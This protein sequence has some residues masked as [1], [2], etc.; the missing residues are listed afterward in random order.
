[1]AIEQIVAALNKML[2]ELKSTAA[3]LR[4]IGVSCGGPLDPHTG[5]I[6]APPNLATWIDVPI[7]KILATE[8]GCPVVL[9]NDANA[10][11]MAEHRYGAGK[12]THHMVFL[13]M[14]TGLGAG[15]IIHDRLYRGANDMAGEVGHVRLTQKGPVG[16]YKAGSVEGWAS[17]GGLAQIAKSVL[18][19]ARRNGRKTLLLELPHEQG[20]TAK[21]VG[22]AAEKGD[23][24]AR[25]ILTICGRK[26]GL[27]LAILV[28]VLNPERIV[29]GGLAMRL[30]DLILEP[31]RQALRKEALQ[32]ALAACRVVP[33]MLG[34]R[35][36]DIAA[37]CV[38][39]GGT[40]EDAAAE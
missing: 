30:G 22:L 39:M 19:D 23:A 37:L 11:A 16:Y 28:D 35:I 27:A 18:N 8:F 10:G 26:L 33:A 36:G 6:Q 1:V 29:I 38:A 5:V 17:G 12:G 14:G 31:A 21:D 32:P 7:V 4:G 3:S 13:T 34:E 40:R 24:V 2:S 9:E 15:I 25:R 20:I